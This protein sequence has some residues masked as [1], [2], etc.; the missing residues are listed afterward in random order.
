MPQP[1][2]RRLAAITLACLL[3]SG[4]V[5]ALAPVASALPAAVSDSP[6]SAFVP[7]TSSSAPTAQARGA[8]TYT[9]ALVAG[10]YLVA[11]EGIVS[12]NGSSSFEMQ[13]DGNAV[14][15][16][17]SGRAVWDT[18]TQ[19]V[20]SYLQMQSDGNL[21]VYSA[22]GAPVWSSR[23]EGTIGAVAL[24]QDDGRLVILRSDSS[25]AWSSE[26]EQPAIQDALTGGR[27][28]STGQQ[29]T[30]SD[31]RSRAALQGD[32]NFVVYTDG[33]ARWNSLTFG[34]GNRLDMQS[35]GNAVI[36]GSAAGARW[37]TNTSGN[38]GARMVMQNDGNLV[39]YAASGRPLWASNPAPA[40]ATT[41]VL[42]GGS[43]LRR[44][45][46]LTSSDGASR[47]VMQGDG[48]VAVY[49]RGGVRWGAGTQGEGDRLAM[50]SDGNAVIYAGNGRALWA[51]GTGGNGGA[52]MVMQNDG[53]L[54]I[55]SASGRA[56]WA[57]DTP[58]APPAPVMSDTLYAGN[59]LTAD[60]RLRSSDGGSEAVMQGD[61]NFAVYS[62]GSVRWSAG[63]S[64]GGNRLEM[65]SDGN[66]VIYGSS[67]ARWQSGT[68]GNPG[69]RMVMQNDGNL[70]IYSTSGRALWSSVQ[71]A[72]PAPPQ[73]PA[74]RDCKDFPSQVAAQNFLEFWA[75]WYGDFARLDANN[76]GVACEDNRY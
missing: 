71:P 51:S 36:Y 49:S 16:D 10:E 39:V 15:Y 33:V 38:P 7:G 9:N 20:G 25:T 26:I 24:I 31:G 42:V 57:S 56:L 70:V 1:A 13:N 44:G 43:D 35:D 41:D 55:Y 37:A 48:N 59:R 5:A 12:A 18:R 19:G 69:A 22:D 58:P 4:G 67:G 60:Q 23:T 54:V 6:T 64:G 63:T 21:V 47:A 30:S 32:G 45:Q 53:N 72:A 62:R 28:L 11:G 29:L 27:S 50:Q 46:Q 2:T 65:Q 61:G 73:R 75:Q 74:D 14:I 52:R 3:A 66:A 17:S 8:Q 40:P 68:G 34:P 76:N